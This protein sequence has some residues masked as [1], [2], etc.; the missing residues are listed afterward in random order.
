MSCAVALEQLLDRYQRCYQSALGEFPRHYADGET[1]V[2]MLA[3]EVDDPVQ[4][5]SV[6][7]PEI[8]SFANVEA[9]LSLSLHPDIEP[10]YGRFFAGPVLFDAPFGCGELLQV[11]NEADFARLQ[12]NIIGHLMM[13]Q[14]LKQAPTWF[15]G[16]LD[17]QDEMLTV[18]NHDGSVWR[19]RPGDVP[20]ERLADN[21]ADFL[22]QLSPRV[23]EA[24][25]H[26]QLVDDHGGPD[27]P[28]IFTSLQRMWRNLFPQR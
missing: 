1:S 4:W 11:W 5:Q 23:S 22:G 3:N 13:K 7:R 26:Q 10:F 24:V 20:C 18:D 9:A 19:E 28:G 15:I 16:V 14:K 17:G 21:L 8:A 6:M 27:H 2:C 25:R 12:Q